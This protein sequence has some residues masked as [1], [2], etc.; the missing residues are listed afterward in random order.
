MKKIFKKKKTKKESEIKA[1]IFDVN[2]VLL[3]GHGRSI[4]EY[5]AKKL[6]TNMDNWFDTIEAYWEDMVKEEFTTEHHLNQIAKHFH[7]PRYKLDRWF[8]KAFK[9]HF[10]K[11]RKMFKLVK[12]LR[13][14]GYKTAILSDQTRMSYQAYKKY[15]LDKRVDITVWSQKEGIRKPNP[16]IYKLTTKRLKLQPE[17][18]LFI[19]D[20]DWNLIP[21]KKIGMKY[22][23]FHN[24]PQLLEKLRVFGIKI[25]IIIF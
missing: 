1:I 20:R 18:C 6:K 8:V 19:D 11:D 3:K 15:K 21:A 17:N 7:V 16:E 4:H 2:G 10:K 23:L 14:N 22:I 24:Y 13:K 5:M 25:Y 12:K 9:K